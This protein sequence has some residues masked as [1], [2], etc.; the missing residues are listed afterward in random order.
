MWFL[1][2]T[3]ATKPPHFNMH[4]YVQIHKYIGICRYI[5]I[6]WELG[7]VVFVPTHC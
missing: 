6:Q 2:T 5:N 4:L 7:T 3:N 1:N